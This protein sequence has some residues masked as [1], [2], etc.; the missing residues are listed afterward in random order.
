MLFEVKGVKRGTGET[1]AVRVQAPDERAAGW[2]VLDRG[3]E[4]LSITPVN[5]PASHR[6]APARAAAPRKPLH[7][8][9]RKVAR[10]MLVVSTVMLVVTIGYLIPSHIEYARV[11]ERAE[12][13]R[14]QPNLTQSEYEKRYPNGWLSRFWEVRHLADA[15]RHE[16]DLRVAIHR[17]WAAAGSSAV[18]FVIAGS[19]QPFRRDTGASQ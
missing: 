10:V 11:S 8:I 18:V 5:A 9:V 6:P 17:L 1:V 14:R 3:I 13:K 2:A 12:L 4:V 16:A 7:P 15:E 19:L